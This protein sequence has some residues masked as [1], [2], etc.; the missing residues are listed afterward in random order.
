MTIRRQSSVL[1]ASAFP[2]TSHNL[3]YINPEEVTMTEA[4]SPVSEGVE[5]LSKEG[6]ALVFQTYDRSMT[7]LPPAPF[8]RSNRFTG[9]RIVSLGWAD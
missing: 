9:R 5:R 2:P 8:Q 7:A 3:F 1:R 6:L 4:S